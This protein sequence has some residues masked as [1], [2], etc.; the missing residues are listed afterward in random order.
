ML[1]LIKRFSNDHENSDFTVE[2]VKSLLSF[3]WTFGS[4]VVHISEQGG[5]VKFYF[6]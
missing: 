2:K 4:I 6:P 3:Q 5:Q 1:S